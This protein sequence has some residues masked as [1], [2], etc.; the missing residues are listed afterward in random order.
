MNHPGLLRAIREN[1]DEDVH[2]LVCADWLEEQGEVDRARLIRLHVELA[3]LCP[4]QARFKLYSG[5]VFPNQGPHKEPHIARLQGEVGELVRRF[6]TPAKW[7]VRQCTVRGGLVEYVDLTG[8]SLRFAEPVLRDHPVW[9]LRL[10]RA[11]EQCAELASS[12]HLDG[13]RMLEFGEI[14]SEDVRVLAASPHLGSLRGIG[15]HNQKIQDL[16]ELMNAPALPPVTRLVIGTSTASAP[17]GPGMGVAMS[18]A[19]R[20]IG[21]DPFRLL[22]E[23][24]ALRAVRELVLTGLPHDPG[25]PA[26][27]GSPYLGELTEV[28]LSACWLGN[29]ILSALLKPGRLGQLQRLNLWA[30]QIGDAGARMLAESPQLSGLKELHLNQNSIGD[31]GA[32]ALA[33]SP[34]LDGLEQL[35]LLHNRIGTAAK[36]ALRDRFGERLKM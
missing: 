19:R 30:N 26:L 10:V 17:T 6:I 5:C 32:R 9:H 1:P 36:A 33:N 28:N 18:H 29:T 23:A 20:P 31:E 4:S 12:P 16:L 22:A 2:R 27:L 25:V 15:L 8:K 11:R 13:V 7:R 34:Y 14:R 21:A 24:P 3:R 35:S